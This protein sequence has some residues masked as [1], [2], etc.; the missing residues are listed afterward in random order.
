VPAWPGNEY[1][2]IFVFKIA[3]TNGVKS[4]SFTVEHEGLN[5]LSADCP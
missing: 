2:M 3:A 1:D 5:G 4:F